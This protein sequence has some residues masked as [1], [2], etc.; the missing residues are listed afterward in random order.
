MTKDALEQMAQAIGRDLDKQREAFM[1]GDPVAKP[2]SG[3]MAWIPR[4]TDPA[5]PMFGV[6]RD[7]IPARLVGP[8]WPWW[9]RALYRAGNRIER[10]GAIVRSW[11]G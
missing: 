1:R 7:T 9:R 6:S 3:V 10:L 11:A 5:T 8:P 4:T 2:Y